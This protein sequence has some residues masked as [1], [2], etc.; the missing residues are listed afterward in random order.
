MSL[1]IWER[2]E[3]RIQSRE[4]RTGDDP[5]ADLDLRILEGEEARRLTTTNA[6][7]LTIVKQ[8]AK[9]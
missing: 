5:E 1:M 2:I 8:D 6:Q 4:Q 7:Y 9:E 3:R